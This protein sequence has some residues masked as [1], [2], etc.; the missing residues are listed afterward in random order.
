MNVTPVPDDAVCGFV[1]AFV[2]CVSF[3]LA[4]TVY[5]VYVRLS[6]SASCA[7]T[8]IFSDVFEFA[9]FATVAW[10]LNVGS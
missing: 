6:P 2:A 9:I 5:R 10:L 8:V 7:V 3:P 1:P 4:S